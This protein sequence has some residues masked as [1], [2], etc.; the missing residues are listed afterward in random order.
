MV[1]PVA[2]CSTQTSALLRCQSERRRNSHS[3]SSWLPSIGQCRGNRTEG[4]Q[5]EQR[6]FPRTPAQAV[7]VCVCV[8]GG[9]GG[10]RYQGKTSYIVTMTTHSGRK[11]ISH[12]RVEM[13]FALVLESNY[14][15]IL[16]Q[17]V[18]LQLRVILVHRCSLRSK[19]RGQRLNGCI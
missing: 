4:W 5:E 9:W 6:P 10:M 13:T 3:C 16:K 1:S 14:K 7:S 12:F 18:V 17:L 2:S 8:R 11:S 19:V 15:H